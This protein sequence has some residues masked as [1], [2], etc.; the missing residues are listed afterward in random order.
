[1]C[2]PEQALAVGPVTRRISDCSTTVVQHAGQA[3]QADERQ[4]SEAV[5]YRS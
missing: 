3:E 2:A 1:M 4:S 5:Q